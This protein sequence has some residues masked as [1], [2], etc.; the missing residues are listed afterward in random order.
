[1]CGVSRVSMAYALRMYYVRLRVW[2]MCDVLG[3]LGIFCGV[4][5]N[6]NASLYMISFFRSHGSDVSHGSGY[7]VGFFSGLRLV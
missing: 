7:R 2:S 4:L 1:M 5:K 3:V 6:L